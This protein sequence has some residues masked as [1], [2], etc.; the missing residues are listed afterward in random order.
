M[1][2]STVGRVGYAE[3]TVQLSGNGPGAEC[4]ICG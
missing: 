4:T 2:Q 3:P 1:P